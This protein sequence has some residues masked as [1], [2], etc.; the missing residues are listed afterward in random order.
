MN[1]AI[2]Q[3]QPKANKAWS[4][5]D[6][7][8]LQEN[9]GIYSVPTLM[10]NLGRSHNAI[11]IKAFKL[12][13]GAFLESGD[14]ITY[15]QILKT[16]GINC[17][18]GYKDISWIKNR[19]FPV[20]NKRVNSN[21]FKVV[22]LEEFWEWV[23]KNRSFV[24]F[25]N[26]PENALGSE[27]EW[28]KEKRMYDCSKKHNFKKSP[29]SK[30]EDD[31][32]TRMLKEFRYSYD[33]LS[34]LLQRTTGAV[35]RR[36]CDLNL[37]ERPIKVDN[38]QMWTDAQFNLLGDLIK[39]SATYEYM[40]TQL[41]KSSKAIRGRVYQMYLTENLDKVRQYMG[42]GNWGT[43]RPD[44]MLKHRSLMSIDEKSQTDV[45]MSN[46]LYMLLQRARSISTVGEEFKDYW[47]KDMCMNWDDIHGCKAGECNCDSCNAFIRMKEQYCKRCGGTFLMRKESLYCDRCLGQRK[48]QAQKKWAVLNGR[49]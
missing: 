24:D 32:L 12:R 40:A 43:G 6:I 39:R 29:W 16:L 14:Y 41:N 33:D 31:R 44:R 45:K 2:Q 34:K 5:Q 30:A 7:V 49:I 15:N 48:K 38:H 27:P 20:H 21:T 11:M 23:S 26:F 35:Q 9:W 13:L 28:V 37:K 1:A 36:I 25:S 42:G 19:D 8:Y 18:S 46:L 4:K 17:G 10:K 22:Y 47:Q 3:L